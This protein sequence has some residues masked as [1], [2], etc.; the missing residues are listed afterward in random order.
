M[1]RALKVNVDVTSVVDFVL[2]DV[3]MSPGCGQEYDAGQA[4][5]C[6]GPLLAEGGRNFHG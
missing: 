2:W 5:D 1:G 6:S 3:R 4:V